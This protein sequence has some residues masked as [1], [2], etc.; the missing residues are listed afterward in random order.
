MGD[1][2]PGVTGKRFGI[3]EDLGWLWH[4]IGRRGHHGTNGSAGTLMAERGEISINM[5]GL[6]SDGGDGQGT[7]RFLDAV[8]AGAGRSSQMLLLYFLRLTVIEGHF[9][10]GNTHSWVRENPQIGLMW[11]ALLR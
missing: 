7:L 1:D 2:L 11:T 5:V 4:G 3:S 10:W 9:G 6:E 8:I